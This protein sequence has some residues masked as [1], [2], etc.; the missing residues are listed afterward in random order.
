[1]QNGS[2]IK[3]SKCRD[4]EPHQGNFS[5]G[6]Y[7]RVKLHLPLYDMS[8]PWEEM[9]KLSE[10]PEP[11]TGLFLRLLI[12]VLALA[13]FVYAL[14]AQA[15]S[16]KIRVIASEGDYGF[17]CAEALEYYKMAAYIIESQPGIR[18]RHKFV[19]KD[20]GL[21]L[22][23]TNKISSF[24]YLSFNK[25]SK[26]KLPTKLISAPLQFND[27]I[28]TGG[29]AHVGLNR[30]FSWSFVTPKNQDS[31]DRSQWALV[32]IAHELGHMLGAYHD[33]SEWSIMSTVA[34]GRLA[35][36]PNQT[37]SFTKRS[38]KE[39]RREVRFYR[40]GLGKRSSQVL[41][42]FNKG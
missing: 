21:N 15:Q 6:Y 41:T 40:R 20:L 12:A 16:V 22:N 27:K 23:L 5:L 8:D 39:I 36:D 34:L 31:E 11:K 2:T 4:D 30:G 19:C 37:L 29:L 33:E 3:I 35:E 25:L 42:C 17:K 1:M 10:K 14:P 7:E 9:K 38:I 32:T 28:Y 24:Y 26:R 18:L 13:A